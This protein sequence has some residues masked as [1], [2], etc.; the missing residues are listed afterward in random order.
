MKELSKDGVV[1]VMNKEI[2]KIVNYSES[3]VSNAIRE[4]IKDGKI[5]KIQKAKSQGR[6]K[7]WIPSVFKIIEEQKSEKSLKI[8]Q[9]QDEYIIEN[10]KNIK[11]KMYKTEEG[12]VVPITDIAGA[13]LYD[14]QSIRDLINRNKDLFKYFTVSITLSDKKNTKCTCLTKEG[15][16]GLIMK[17][18]I[19]RAAKHKRKQILEFQ[20][21]AIE[22]L[23]ILISDGK[24]ELSEQEHAKVQN[25]IG[26]I[27]DMTEEQIDKLFND[28]QDE[29]IGFLKEVKDKTNE[30]VRKQKEEFEYKIKSLDNINKRMVTQAIELRNKLYERNF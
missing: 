29:M 4:L 5:E 14:R 2:A 13:I 9:S 7:E 20:K 6:G 26:E 1:K 25:N 23:S 27:T 8:T 19:S 21:W 3:V 24:V 12:Y 30:T 15:I 17:I 16:I 18:N 22:K 11:I 28:I 10:F